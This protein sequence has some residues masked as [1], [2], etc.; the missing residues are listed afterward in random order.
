MINMNVNPKESVREM[1]GQEGRGGKGGSA[2][3]FFDSAETLE[4]WTI[5]L[6]A[7]RRVW[8][9]GLVSKFSIAP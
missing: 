2:E 6:A 7:A 8:V 5:S 9:R 1:C 3:A 4:F